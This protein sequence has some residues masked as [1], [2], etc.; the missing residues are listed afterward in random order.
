MFVRPLGTVSGGQYWVDKCVHNH[1][2]TH[3]SACSSLQGWSCALLKLLL[4]GDVEVEPGP[5]PSQWSVVDWLSGPN[6]EEDLT[7]M[8]LGGND[9]DSVWMDINGALID[10]QSVIW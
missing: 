9:D 1:L 10:Q 7:A 5:T 4:G 8:L 2:C 6:D 3:A